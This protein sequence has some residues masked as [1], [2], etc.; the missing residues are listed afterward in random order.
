[1]SQATSEVCGAHTST[2]SIYAQAFL[3]ARFPCRPPASSPP[4]R[5]P[6]RHRFNSEGPAEHRPPHAC[7]EALQCLLSHPLRRPRPVRDQHPPACRPDTA[8]RLRPCDLLAEPPCL[9]LNS[10]PLRQRLHDDEEAEGAGLLHPER[11]VHAPLKTV[12]EIN[13]NA[14]LLLSPEFFSS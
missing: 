12:Q 4:A 6:R 10:S 7:R 8:T 1:M 13:L 5:P 9:C 14:F 11:E 2:S 3:V